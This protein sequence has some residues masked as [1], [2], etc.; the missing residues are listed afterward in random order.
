MPEPPAPPSSAA[1]ASPPPPPTGEMV[2]Y[3]TEDG[4]TRVECRF[5]DQTMWLS[6]ALIADLFQV[7]TP[8]VNEHLRN[9]YAEM[10]QSPQATIRNFRIV[11]RE[12]T[13]E[14]A[15]DIEHYNLDA[16]L[17]VGYRVRSERG[18]QFRRWATE[19]LRE[20]LVKGFT[21]D[22]QRL[23]NPP[24]EGSGV[25]D[26]FDELLERIRDIRASEKRMY[27]RVREIFALAGDYDPK[28]RHTTEF[29]QTI[30]NR[31]HFAATGKTAPELIAGRADHT[32]PNMGLTSWHGDAVRKADVTIAKNYLNQ[33]EIQELNRIV[34]MWLDFAEDQARRRKQ[35]F[36]RDWDEKLNDFLRFNERAV[37]RDKGQVSKADADA[38]AET[39]Y[40]AFAARRRALLEAE[41]ERARQA[42]IEE[43]ARQFPPPKPKRGRGKP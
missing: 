11:R 32:Q 40:A 9:I 38:R 28:N 27:L 26:H 30:Q 10:E 41:G 8:T 5:A 12:G 1:P 2:L 7:S 14:V 43:A 16:I 36:L 29:F 34:T 3:Q 31:L 19:R 20:Y 24:V 22:D 17:A 39:E 23:K 37:L 42:S 6:Q 33:T 13:R 25:P 21:L 35:V 4:R 18:V 15:R